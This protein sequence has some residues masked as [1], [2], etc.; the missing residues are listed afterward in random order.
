MARK[1]EI[2]FAFFVGNTQVERLSEEYLEEMS[3]RLS[4]RMSDYYTA[5]PEEFAALKQSRAQST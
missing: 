3:R 5:H 2:T 4:E 1:K